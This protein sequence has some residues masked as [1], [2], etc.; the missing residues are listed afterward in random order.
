MENLCEG[1]ITIGVGPR[2]G[3]GCLREENDDGRLEYD[4][5]PERPHCGPTRRR[6]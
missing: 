4:G 5:E 3:G 2:E 6:I 1:G